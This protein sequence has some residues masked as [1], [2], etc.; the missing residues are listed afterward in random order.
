VTA[1]LLLAILTGVCALLVQVRALVRAVA[2]LEARKGWDDVLADVKARTLAELE[3]VAG[4]EP[5]TPTGRVLR[6]VPPP[7]PPVEPSGAD[8]PTEYR[9]PEEP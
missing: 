8:E 1:A 3:A 5:P 4:P 7:R 2:R 9:D 6:L